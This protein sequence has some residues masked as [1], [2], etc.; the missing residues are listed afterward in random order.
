MEKM[1]RISLPEPNCC[2]LYHHSRTM[3]IKQLK[4]VPHK[5]SRKY[6]NAGIIQQFHWI[7]KKII[8]ELDIQLLDVLFII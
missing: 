7:Y 1:N 2:L 5:S 4:Y 6:I 3:Q 8:N